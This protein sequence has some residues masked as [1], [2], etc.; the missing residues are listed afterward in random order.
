[1]SNLLGLLD[2]GGSGLLSHQKAIQ[3]TGHNIANVNTPGYTRQRVNLEA[4]PPMANTPGQ[5]G[6]GVNVTEIQRIFDRFLGVQINS[7]N[8]ELGR[9][10]AQKGALE[11]TEIIFD[12]FSGSGLN[13]AMSEFW[14][15]WQ[16][17]V[18]NP[19][20]YTERAALLSKSRH[21][22]TT[23]NTISSDIQQQQIQLDLN[24]EATVN[25]INSMAVQIFDLNKKI[26]EFEISGQSANDYRDQRE[27]LLKELSSKIDI[28]T[29]EDS[30]GRITVSVGNGQ[31]LVDSSYP[32]KLSTQTNAFGHADVMWMDN[33]GNTVNITQDISGGRLKGWLQAR[34][35]DMADYLTRLDT[36]AGEMIF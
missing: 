15:S 35:T 18:N 6:T 14:N 9:W 16:D 25:E 7:E 34:D 36:L 17:V 28:N 26:S 13:A 10:E 24:I 33:T 27:E 4:R 22:A 1:M 32:W 11:I 12:E 2:L 31:P 19:A 30:R 20:G 8:Q 5:A 3:V 29:F 23:I 21:L